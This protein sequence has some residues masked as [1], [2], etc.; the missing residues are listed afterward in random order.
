M[1]RVQ[2]PGMRKRELKRSVHIFPTIIAH[3]KYRGDSK[4][5]KGNRTIGAETTHCQGLAKLTFSTIMI[6]V[7]KVTKNPDSNL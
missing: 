4:K 1:V 7:V 3:Q 5:Y 2:Q 6:V